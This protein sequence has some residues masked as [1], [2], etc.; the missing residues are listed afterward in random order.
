MNRDRSI[1]AE[2]K[3]GHKLTNGFHPIYGAVLMGLFSISLKFNLSLVYYG[4]NMWSSDGAFRLNIR[5]EAL[6]LKLI[7]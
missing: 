5:I 7:R 2:I 4:H 6:I 1:R 3:S